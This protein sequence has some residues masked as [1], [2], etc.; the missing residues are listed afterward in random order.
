MMT[1]RD[2]AVIEFEDNF[3]NKR[4]LEVNQRIYIPSEIYWLLKS[5]GY[6]KIEIFGVNLGQFSR[7]HKLQRTNIAL[8]FLKT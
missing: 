6:Q 8:H 7:K 4:Q 2:H 1:F 5:L 3:G